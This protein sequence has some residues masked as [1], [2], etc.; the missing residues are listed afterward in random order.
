MLDAFK[1]VPSF[2]DAVGGSV[3]QKREINLFLIAIMTLLR[4]I[5][6][7]MKLR[8]YV[9]KTQQLKNYGRFL[10]VF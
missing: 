8:K 2:N 10:M 1:L 5:K 4:D 6:Q 7:K 9:A 3:Q